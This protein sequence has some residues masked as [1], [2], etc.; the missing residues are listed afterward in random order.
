MMFVSQDMLT[1]ELPARSVG[2][3]ISLMVS[4]RLRLV[5]HV[6]GVLLVVTLFLAILVFQDTN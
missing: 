3:G 6:Q 2:M 1:Q 5:Y 4:F